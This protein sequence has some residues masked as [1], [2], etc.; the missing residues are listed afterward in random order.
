MALRVPSVESL[1]P[2]LRTQAE[3]QLSPATPPEPQR[4]APKKVGRRRDD[5]HNEQVVFF[6][7]IRTL[8]L[9]DPRFAVAADRT[10]AIPNGG[11]RSKAQAGRL[12]AEGVRPGVLDIFCSFPGG[13][14][15]GLYIEMKSLTGYPSREQRAWIAESVRL[16]YHAAC[17][18]GAGEAMKVWREYVE[19]SFT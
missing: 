12:R 16:G 3:R 15:H 18:R 11:G 4:P 14:H 10:Y 13:G 7:R 19:A 1:P 9:N 6:N 8:A 2:H 17:C 5:E